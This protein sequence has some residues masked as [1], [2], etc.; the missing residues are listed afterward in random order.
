MRHRQCTR[1]LLCMRTPVRFGVK[2]GANEVTSA[3]VGNFRV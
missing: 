3:A 1:H 2:D